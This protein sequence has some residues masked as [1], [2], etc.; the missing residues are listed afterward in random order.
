[1]GQ[2]RERAEHTGAPPARGA[3]GRRR[4]RPAGVA[5]EEPGVGPGCEALGVVVGGLGRPGS[6]VIA[7]YRLNTR[8]RRFFHAVGMTVS[9][10]SST[11]T[12]PMSTFCSSTTGTASRL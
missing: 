6:P 9:I 5:R 3:R 1:M 4:R 10:A 7:P 12:M 2:V 8:G 11:V